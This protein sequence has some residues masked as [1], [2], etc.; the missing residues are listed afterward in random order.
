MDLVARHAAALNSTEI[1]TVEPATFEEF[2]AA[3]PS[4]LAFGNSVSFRNVRKALEIA[5]ISQLVVRI[6]PRH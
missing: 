5:G 2:L 6:E 1:V 3:D 4:A